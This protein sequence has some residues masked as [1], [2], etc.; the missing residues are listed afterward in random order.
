[1]SIKNIVEFDV[2]AK[3]E[4]TG[5]DYV[6]SFSAKTK[7]STREQIK[8]DEIYRNI[9][10]VNSQEASLTSKTM[11]AAVSYLSVHLMTKPSWW[12]EIGEGLDLEDMNVL[13]IVNNTCQ[14]KIEAEY[15]SLADEAKKA[16]ADLKA[17][18]TV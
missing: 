3:G 16:E 6:G 8:Q 12:K 1:M 15:Q 18:Q 11:A 9:L 13:A 5:K 7:L 4:L 2:S 14:Q 10:G 17:T